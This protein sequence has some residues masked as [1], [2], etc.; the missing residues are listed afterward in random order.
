MN[1]LAK[2]WKHLPECSKEQI[3][4]PGR[5]RIKNRLK[6]S[7]IERIHISESLQS[8]IDLWSN[9]HHS[10]LDPKRSTEHSSDAACP[11]ATIYQGL[12]EAE[13]RSS[14]DLIRLRFL[15]VLFHHLQDRFC[16]TY[17]RL[18]SVEWM[19]RRVIAAGLDSSDE[20]KISLRIKD[21]ACVGA[22]YDALC[23]ELGSYNAAQDYRYLG[24]LFRLPSDFTDRL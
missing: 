18:N 8:N 22:R 15:K 14:A 20:E 6:K 12:T 2:L 4:P 3:Y 1:C 13:T 11:I 5:S 16:V 21:W 10:F 24:N 19:T 17:L 9:D 7:K 23:R